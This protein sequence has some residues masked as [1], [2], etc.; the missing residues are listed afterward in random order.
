MNG[1]TAFIR[2]FIITANGQR[3]H[4][5]LQG[6]LQPGNTYVFRVAPYT[7]TYSPGTPSASASIFVNGP[8]F[9]TRKYIVHLI[10][11]RYL[12]LNNTETHSNYQG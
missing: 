8:S 10:V 6:S 3:T 4:S 12:A 2:G 1:N 7:A 9:V 11:F 5:V